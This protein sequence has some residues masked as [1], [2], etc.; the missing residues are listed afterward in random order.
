MLSL[1]T[2]LG[3]SLLSRRQVLTNGKTFQGKRG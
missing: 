3:G 1:P 2:L